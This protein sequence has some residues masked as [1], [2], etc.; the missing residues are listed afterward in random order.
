MYGAF[1]EEEHLAS[2]KNEST[3]DIQE[4]EEYFRSTEQ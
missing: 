4:S 1:N 2:K 3:D